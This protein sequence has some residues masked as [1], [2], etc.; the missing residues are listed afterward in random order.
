MKWKHLGDAEKSKTDPSA[1]VRNL[2]RAAALDRYGVR[3]D[4][5]KR[6]ML[7]KNLTNS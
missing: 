5:A 6:R 3:V 2:K 1:V 7:R 4:A